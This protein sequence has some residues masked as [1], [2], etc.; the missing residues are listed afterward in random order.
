M[1]AEVIVDIAHS[2]VDKIFEYRAI[3]GVKAGSRVRVPFGRIQV[4]GYVMRL[5]EKSDFDADKLRPIASVI[6]DALTPECLSLVQSLSARYRCPK[7]L[8]L[9]LFLPGEM[10]K[11]AVRE[12]VQNVE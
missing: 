11:G 6:D 1:V 2:E 3:D 7:A 12:Q 10:R 9:R 8:V 5:K 4:D